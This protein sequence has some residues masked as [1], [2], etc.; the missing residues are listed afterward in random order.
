[1]SQ[2]QRA[3]FWV[4]IVLAVAALVYALDVFFE[5]LRL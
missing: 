1:M 3:L 4:T 5:V 2:A